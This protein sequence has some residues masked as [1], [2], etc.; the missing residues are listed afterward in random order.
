MDHPEDHSLIFFVWSTGLSGQI[1][2]LIDS[3]VEESKETNV[4]T[5]NESDLPCLKLRIGVWET[6]FHLGRPIFRCYL[7]FGEG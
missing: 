5:L 7:S 3:Q 6:T 2:T 1:Y 4:P